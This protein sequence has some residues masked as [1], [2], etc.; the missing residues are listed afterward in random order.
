MRDL[1]RVPPFNSP[2]IASLVAIPRY[3]EANPGIATR[4]KKLML[5][6]NHGP[7]VTVG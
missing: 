3:P 6:N 5:I 4:A 7:G 1:V 2:A